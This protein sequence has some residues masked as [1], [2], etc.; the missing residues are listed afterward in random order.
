MN[1]QGIFDNIAESLARSY[2]IIYY[3][4][5]ENGNYTRFTSAKIYGD[6]HVKEDG[7]NFF[8]DAQKNAEKII[9]PKD[10]ERVK[11][12]LKKESIISALEIKKLYTFDYTLMIDGEPRF[13][14]AT[15]SW[16]RDRLHL[17]VGVEDTVE[18]IRRENALTNVL[19]LANE[20][21]RRDELTGI[22]N[23]TAFDE[24]VKAI[25]ENINNGL[26]YL[27]FALIIC[28]VGGI[29]QL[30]ESF[31]SA[32]GD[33]HIIASC[34]LICN[35]FTHSPVFRIDGDKFAV[36]LRGIDYENRNALFEDLHEQVVDNIK[37]KDG[38]VLAAGMAVFN[39]DEDNSFTSVFERAENLMYKDKKAIK[40]GEAG[41]SSI[42]YINGDISIP[43]D[44]KEKLDRLFNA[45]SIFAEGTYVYLC[46][47][48]YDYSRWSKKAV[49]L[50]G[51]PSEYMVNAAKIWDSHIHPDDAEIY[52]EGIEAIFSGKT[53]SHDMQ[54][55][56]R[57]INGEYDV[58][59]CRGTVMYSP[60][61][62][63]EYFCGTIRNHSIQGHIDTL[64]GLQNQY[65]FFEDI[66]AKILKN[67][68]FKVVM[69]GL[70]KFSEINDVYGYHFGNLVLQKYGRYLYENVGTY[71]TVY[72]LDGTKFAVIIPNSD[73]TVENIKS[74]YSTMRHYFRNEFFIDNELIILD[75]SA[76]LLSVDNF[77]I[78]PQTVYACLNYAY[79]E[80][81]LRRQGDIVEFGNSINKDK[82]HRTEVLHVIRS[83]IMQ[84]FQGFFLLYQPVVDAL[85][86]KVIGAEALLRWKN[87]EYGM[88]PPDSFI[89]VLEKDPIF[90]EL[91]QWILR[92][93]LI[94]A[95]KLREKFPD[96]IINVN[97]S[98]NQLEKPNFVDMVLATLA[99]TDYPPE[100]LC[101]EITERCRL[102]DMDLLKNIV[103]NLRGRGIKIALDDF[104]TG[105][106]SIGI[107]KSL[108]FD[109]IKIDRSL[110]MK[111]EENPQDRQLVGAVANMMRSYSTNVCVEG[112]ETAAMRDILLNYEVDCLQGYYYSKPIP[113]EDF[114]SKFDA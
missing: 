27:P 8:S 93:A 54:Y 34:K 41:K 77:N 79:G 71:G 56:A 76:G 110:V 111:I 64:T 80:S 97:L 55:R 5:A 78:D 92:T 29:T 45:F 82:K 114:I 59:T 72:R 15:V 43:L 3:I 87:E 1:K 30:N 86:E 104:G 65:G 13:A 24:L 4:N 102:L 52:R 70:A 22:K 38:P 46:D 2:D 62:I 84:D 51:L 28:D 47:M 109:V 88:V 37:C 33:G 9:A 105:F 35:I 74:K 12:K 103:V 26:V 99:E 95:K 50:F 40:S 106:S 73:H 63:P 57:K 58:C 25:Q 16:A 61:G 6:D 67:E 81:K 89:P 19:S 68:P 7:K 112:I 90:F 48:R 96:F 94:G 100:A 53:N 66:E 83:S 36:L 108:P 23:K 20:V 42:E 17:I 98:Y 60:K 69:V 21:T 91:G 75:T 113:I 14:R 49:D 32:A 10:L 39:S 107:V 101:L 18:E 44:R 11:F 31:S 85:T